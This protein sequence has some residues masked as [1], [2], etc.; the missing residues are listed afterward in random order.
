MGHPA[1]GVFQSALHL[2]NHLRDEGIRPR[3]ISPIK[4][5]DPFNKDQ[6]F[7]SHGIIPQHFAKLKPVAP[8]LSHLSLL[9]SPRW[10][11]KDLI[12][13]GLSNINLPILGDKPRNW[14]WVVTVHDTIPLIKGTGLKS[15]LI[16][17]YRWL[18][19][20]VVD[21]ADAVITVSKWTRSCL[22]DAFPHVKDK[23]HVI[24]NGFTEHRSD[25]L[26]SRPPS[27]V[28]RTL[29]VARG[30]PYKRLDRL[31]TVFRMYPERL[32]CTLVTDGTGLRLISSLAPDL[33]D[34]G[35]FRIY[36][37]VSREILATLYQ[38]TDVYLHP[39]LYEGFCLPA[40]EAI[41]L[42]K[43]VVYQSG[44]GIDEVAGNVVGVA[45]APDAPEDEW[46]QAIETA[47]ARSHASVWPLIVQREIA[48]QPSW[49][50]SAE[51]LKLLYANLLNT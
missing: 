20:R 45:L 37:D 41:S 49:K 33:V 23:I 51:A 24:P 36:T 18:L 44:S 14:R 22:I 19:P 39:S 40:A 3:L 32:N 46:I 26:F 43:P 17:Q 47:F 6:T 31:I 9:R 11:K 25:N 15:K 4:L 5:A 10:R 35:F 50:Q 38:N 30:E 7:A 13:H 29:T 12:F 42:G 2:Y 27:R 48:R 21:R 8:Y 1:S 28:I 16:L 34:S